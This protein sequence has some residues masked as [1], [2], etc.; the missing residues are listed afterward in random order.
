MNMLISMVV[1]TCIMYCECFFHFTLFELYNYPITLR[2]HPPQGSSSVWLSVFFVHFLLVCGAFQYHDSWKLCSCAFI[3]DLILQFAIILFHFRSF[4]RLQV[5]IQVRI[6]LPCDVY[7]SFSDTLVEVSGDQNETGGNIK[8]EFSAA[9][10]E[11][12]GSQTRR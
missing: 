12:A 9:A 8:K 2:A 4:F 3:S 5:H 1:A 6:W 11:P 10:V 7:C